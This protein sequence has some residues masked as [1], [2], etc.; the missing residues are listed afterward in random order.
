MA[1]TRFYSMI[2]TIPTDH[3]KHSI[4][5]FSKY[6][7]IVNIPTYLGVVRTL[8]ER[9]RHDGKGRIL[10]M[11]KVGYSYE[12]QQRLYIVKLGHDKVI[13]QQITPLGNTLKEQLATMPIN[14]G[15]S[16]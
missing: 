14:K 13:W 6:W 16:K 7:N 1:R 5:T 15:G 8:R 11:G 4:F 2:I 3:R 9:T 12:T 10:C